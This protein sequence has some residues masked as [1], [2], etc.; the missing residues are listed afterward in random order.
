MDIAIA[1]LVI[2]DR[3]REVVRLGTESKI[4][5]A[6]KH[7]YPFQLG[8]EEIYDRSRPIAWSKIPLIKKMLTKHEYVFC[9]DADVYFMNDE[10]QLED[11]ITQ[12]LDGDSDIAL[13]RDWQDINFGNVLFKNTPWVF[14]MLDRIYAQTEFIEHDW[15]EQRAFIELYN[16]D[17]EVRSKTTII[18]PTRKL[19]AYIFCPE[20][21]DV[22]VSNL[23]HPGDFLIHL[24][25][26]D[27]WNKL[28]ELMNLCQQ[29]KSDPEKQAGHEAITV[30]I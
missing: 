7:N 4:R 9:S 1:S 10:V 8:G 20:G 18:T 2:G 17:E 25:G 30:S 21:I 5:Y 14:Q 23:Y 24:A 3:Y 22:P 15:W 11:Y 13:T 12:Y 27:D 16:N 6:H 19:N 28:H 26:I 29:L